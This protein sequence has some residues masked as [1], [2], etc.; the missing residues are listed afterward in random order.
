MM[1][2]HTR[3]E[4]LFYYFGLED[5]VPEDLLLRL[6]DTHFRCWRAEESD[7]AFRRHSQWAKSLTSPFSTPTPV[8]NSCQQIPNFFVRQLRSVIAWTQ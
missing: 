7:Q 1:G 3:S 5:Q 8:R 4:W 2:H 6:I